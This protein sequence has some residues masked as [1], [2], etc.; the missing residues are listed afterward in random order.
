MTVK[1]LTAAQ[2]EIGS[3]LEV[4]K[5]E[6]REALKAKLSSLASEGGFSVQELFGNKNGSAKK[7]GTVAPKYRNPEN[8]HQ[9]WSGRGRQPL[10]YVAALKKGVKPERLLIK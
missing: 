8:G 5:L 10:W 9:L 1:E 4:K 6:E 3:L 7:G 2:A